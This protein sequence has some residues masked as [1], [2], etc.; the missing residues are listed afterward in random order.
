MN[1]VEFCISN[2]EDTAKYYFHKVMVH[3][4][5]P[6]AEVLFE[7]MSEY[8]ST[9]IIP[10]NYTSQG[11]ITCFYINSLSAVHKIMKFDFMFLY[12]RNMFYVDIY[13]NDKTAMQYFET[14]MTVEDVV[15]EIVSNRLNEK[16]ELNLSNFCNDPEFLEKKIYFYKIT[17]LAHYKIL[18]LR[19]G[20]DAKILNLSDNNLSEMPQDI[21]NFF[22]RGNLVGLN[23]SNNNIQY[24]ADLHRPSSKIEKI[25]LEG[26]PVCEE[27]DPEVY[28]KQLIVKFPRVTEIDGIKL[29]EHG[30]MFPFSRNYSVT[31]DKKTKMVV[32][33][34]LTLYYSHYDLYPRNIETFYDE[35]ASLC[36][37]T[38]HRES[39]GQ[40]SSN[41]YD[42]FGRNILDNKNL[43]LYNKKCYRTRNTIATVLNRFPAC[44][45]DP[46][47]FCVDVL[48]HDSKT[49]ILIVDGIFKE[50]SINSKSAER[51]F[52]FRRTFIFTIS[53]MNMTS[54]YFINYDMFSISDATEQQI[55]KSFK[56]PIRN[57]NTLTLINP[58]PEEVEAVAK[59]FCHLTQL[60]KEEAKLR[61]KANEWNFHKALTLFMSELKANKISVDRFV[62]DGGESSDDIS[63]LS[64]VD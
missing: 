23:L 31:A 9:V 8:F 42:H 27:M 12:Q 51:F 21:L 28:I 30:F 19:M 41:Y 58:D 49:L 35:N 16:L 48:L 54:I 34:F 6:S 24:L 11:D 61:L 32:E 4:W 46:S 43:M 29:Y 64:D 17:L 13:L 3:N 25:W 39:E 50:K 38:S 52:Q 57:M 7:T 20:R 36:I 14:K 60:K 33:K 26:N 59:A 63:T 2:E 15:N 45:H 44:S 55:E 40:K 62:G 37:S 18:M 47:T 53:V 56:N 1:S 5:L 10:V 22:I